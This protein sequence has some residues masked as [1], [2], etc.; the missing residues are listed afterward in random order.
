MYFLG[1]SDE[2]AQP[3]AFRKEVSEV[4]TEVKLG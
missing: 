1:C 2:E 4:K 3:K